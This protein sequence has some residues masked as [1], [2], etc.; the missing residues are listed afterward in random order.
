ME[1]RLSDK[2]RLPIIVYHSIDDFGTAIS[3]APDVFRN[4]IRWFADHGYQSISLTEAASRI[5]NGQPLPPRSVVLT[6]DDGM[7]SIR[8]VADPILREH[9]FTATTFVITGLVGRKP[10]WYRLHPRYHD[11][12]LLD[13][14]ALKGLQDTGWELQPH[15]HVHP[16]LSHLPLDAQVE[17]IAQ[18]RELVQTWFGVPGDVLAYPFGQ[19]NETTVEAMA[20]CDMAA[21]VT[22]AFSVNVDTIAP[23]SWSRI[24]SAWFKRSKM[25]QML[26]MNG[27]LEHYVRVRNAIKGDRSQHFAEPTEETTQGL[28]SISGE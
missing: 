25:R 11:I 19:S 2:V 6:F 16:V 18:S 8:D 28:I 24:G 13:V 27:L 14:D 10:C 26:A 21:G 23:Y 17:Q 22:L 7:P 4:Q 9:G 20:A 5:R 3:T 15:T 1:P 12:P